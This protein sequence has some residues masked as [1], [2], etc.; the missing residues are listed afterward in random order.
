MS[1]HEKSYFELTLADVDAEVCEGLHE[2]HHYRLRQAL[3]H[4]RVDDVPQLVSLLLLVSEKAD[5]P[6]ESEQLPHVV[7]LVL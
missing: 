2:F 4:V 7:P 1:E 6:S 3:I 5:K